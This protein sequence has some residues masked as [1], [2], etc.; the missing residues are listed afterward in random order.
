M[1]AVSPF[2]PIAHDPR[3]T[4]P[5]PHSFDM[6]LTEVETLL[7]RSPSVALGHYRCRV[8]HP[9]FSGGGP[10]RCPY[11]VFPRSSVRIA[12]LHVPPMVYTPNTI[13]FH[14]IGDVYQRSAIS[15]EGE[16]CDW[17]ALAP[18]LLREMSAQYD[19]A[20]ADRERI[21][22][23]PIAPAAPAIYLAQRALFR[24]VREDP[25]MTPLEL[26]EHTIAIVDAV[27]RWS[28]G[29]V[30]KRPL[31]LR[32]DSARAARIVDNA[33]ALLAERYQSA[34]GI[35]EISRHV[36]AS[37]SY[38]ARRF[39]QRTGFSLHEYQQQLRLR[40]SLDLMP[41]AR[42]DLTGLAVYL[43]FSSHSHFTSVFR[44]RFGLTPSL[45]CEWMPA[46]R[47]RALRQAMAA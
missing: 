31:R 38:L 15:A 17:I 47:V 43:G 5:A 14:E 37:P 44:R 36:H 34:L 23:A 25:A 45:F 46:S 10:Q 4:A 35:E 40:A 1:S 39:R 13:S 29:R 32:C 11:I 20:A 7:R 9:R 30:G 6:D 8:D 28:F 22:A 42:G 26:D 41:H 12:R 19:V 33:V 3:P 16:R 21:F 24:A 27:L 2:A 18:E